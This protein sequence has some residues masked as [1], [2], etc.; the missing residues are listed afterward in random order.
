MNGN[1]CLKRGEGSMKHGGRIVQALL[2]GILLAGA[3]CPTADGAVQST[4]E[5]TGGAG[6]IYVAGNPDWYPVEYYDPDTEC[7]AGVLPQLLERV[8][9]RTGLNFTYV[10]A[11]EED[12]R[13][14]LAQNRQVEMVSGIAGGDSA[15]DGLGLTFS[16]TVLTIP[17]EDGACQVYFAFTE[18]AGE[19]LAAAVVNALRE[20]PPQEIA[21]LALQFVVTHPEEPHAA[22][23]PAAA[24]AVTFLLLAAVMILALRLRGYRKGA[25][26]D[27]EYDPATGIGNKIYFTHRFEQQ[28]ADQY[29]ELYCVA[30]IGFDIERVNQYYGEMEAEDQLRFAAHELMLGTAD[31]EIAARVSGGGFAV[32]R[33]SGG[34]KETGIWA[35][36]MIEH[37][38]RYTEKYGKDYRPEF[39]MGIYM[40][41]A[42]DRDAEMVLFSA[43]QGYQ[44]AVDANLP[45]AFSHAEALKREN[46]AM[47]LKKQTLEAIQKQEF[48]MYLQFVISGADGQII[49]AEALSRWD[50]PQKGLLYPGSYVRL[51]EA[52]KTVSALDFY[53]FEEACKQ[54]ER[55]QGDKRQMS[56]SCNFA[57]VSIDH[58]DFIPQLQ[59]IVSQYHFKHD[60][61]VIEITEDSMEGNKEVA[62]AN[63]SK[64]KELGFRIALDDAGSGYTSFSDLRDY[65]IDIVKID[66]SILNAAVNQRGV[67]LLKGMISLIHNMQMEALCEGVE[68]SAQSILLR[69]LGCDYMQ[70]Y[71]F[72]RALP[73]EEADRVLNRS[74]HQ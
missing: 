47:Q 2:C 64:C 7:Y 46:E 63:I 25:G 59:R 17:G 60:R 39:H 51:M 23:L 55:W 38:N 27:E 16:E 67:S 42:S 1:L 71:Y 50:H 13:I 53:I 58:A 68:T 3:L 62:F 9:E 19:Q 65:P 8:S 66:R 30:F 44:R 26:Q 29:R 10:R 15:L 12:Q 20:I 43:R 57:R 40:L 69:Q 72:Y 34:A 35:E 4:P 61:L 52:D 31:N 73:K 70:G 11:G 24:A 6:S 18:I 5:A 37:L 54:L 14:R 22:W 49:G 56:I 28:I 41:Q 48:R 21:G 74:Y 32:A 45:Y 36:K 33:P